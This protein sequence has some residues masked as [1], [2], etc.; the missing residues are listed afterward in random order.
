MILAVVV[1]FDGDEIDGFQYLLIEAVPAY[2][3]PFVAIDQLPV[4]SA[5]MI[6]FAYDGFAIIVPQITTRTYYQ[7]PCCR[8][9][10]S[11]P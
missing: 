6:Q 7:R 3:A 2:F 8:W 9:M 5:V 11:M 10:S 1:V 4:V